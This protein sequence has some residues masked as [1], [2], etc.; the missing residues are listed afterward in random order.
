MVD[1]GVDGTF[2]CSICPFDYPYTS[3]SDFRSCFENRFAILLDPDLKFV[4]VIVSISPD[5][6]LRQQNS[7]IIRGRLYLEH[8]SQAD[9]QTKRRGTAKCQ[10]PNCAAYEIWQTYSA[11]AESSIRRPTTLS[12]YFGPH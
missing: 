3:F 12:E 4:A 5:I 8:R 2:F 9:W 6:W 11:P 10:P 1:P 7:A